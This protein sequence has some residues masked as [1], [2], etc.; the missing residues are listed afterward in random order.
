M[1]L[2]VTLAIW[3][4]PPI[5]VIPLPEE[6]RVMAVQPEV[7]AGCIRSRVEIEPLIQTA[8]EERERL[9]LAMTTEELTEI[10]TAQV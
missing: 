3:L 6:A 4:K 5:A 7:E 2:G 9:T 1:A 8:P 10:M